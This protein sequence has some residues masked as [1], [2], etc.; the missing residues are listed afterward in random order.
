M[1]KSED[2]NMNNS[3]PDTDQSRTDEDGFESIC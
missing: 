1:Y 3:I 2:E